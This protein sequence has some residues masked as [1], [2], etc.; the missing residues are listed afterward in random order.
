MKTSIMTNL[1]TLMPIVSLVFLVCSCMDLV[2]NPAF[3]FDM[4]WDQRHALRAFVSFVAFLG[5]PVAYIGN[6]GFQSNSA[7]LVRFFFGYILVSAIVEGAFV[8]E[9]IMHF[10]PCLL[11]EEVGAGGVLRECNVYSGLFDTC[12]F[13]LV[14]FQLCSLVPLYSAIEDMDRRGDKAPLIMDK[15][16]KRQAG[17]YLKNG[18]LSGIADIL[19][20][21]SGTETVLKGGISEKLQLLPQ[22]LNEKLV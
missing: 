19:N 4:P 10:L 16:S 1:C 14:C 3:F 15:A 20:A 2:S 7:K 12:L 9:K 21:P 11:A 17:E 5:F 22:H 8:M 18:H 6:E 13:S